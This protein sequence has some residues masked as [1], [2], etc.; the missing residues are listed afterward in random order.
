MFTIDDIDARLRATP[1][2]PARIVTSSGVADEITQP[3]LV[4]LGKRSMIIGT[5][6]PDHPR[7][8]DGFARVALDH[9]TAMNDLSRPTTTSGS[10]R[11]RSA[12]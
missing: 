10:R 3:E 9:I 6:V 12:S 1:F 5:A 11:R 7:V 4:V 8:A 2:V